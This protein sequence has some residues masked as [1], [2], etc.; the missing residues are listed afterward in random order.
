MIAGAL[1]LSFMFTASV[2]SPQRGK[3]NPE[4]AAVTPDMRL[5]NGAPGFATVVDDSSPAV[6]ADRS[7]VLGEL[8]SHDYRIQIHA[9]YPDPTYTIMTLDGSVLAHAITREAAVL[10]FPA[11]PASVFAVGAGGDGTVTVEEGGHAGVIHSDG[12]EQPDRTDR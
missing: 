6:T 10:R 3:A 5:R 12:I 4:E 9:G 2:I 11:L 7:S 8:V 1:I